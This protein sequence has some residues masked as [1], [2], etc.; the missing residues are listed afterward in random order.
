MWEM[1]ERGRPVLLGHRVVV[2]RGLTP[3]RARVNLDVRAGEF[4]KRR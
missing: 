1:R 3:C 2:Q 4:E